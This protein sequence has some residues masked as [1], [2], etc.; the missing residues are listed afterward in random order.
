[1]NYKGLRKRK[2][3]RLNGINAFRKSIFKAQL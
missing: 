2:Y 3:R 1:M